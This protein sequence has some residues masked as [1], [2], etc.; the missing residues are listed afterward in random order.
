[1][2]LF[3]REFIEIFL[4]ELP[5]LPPVQKISFGIKLLPEIGLISKSSYRMTSAELKELQT[6][7]QELLDKDF[8]RPSYSP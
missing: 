2:C 4:E 8:I 3:V 1:M 5:G 6:Q 7:L